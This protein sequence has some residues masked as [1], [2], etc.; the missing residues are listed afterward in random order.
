[1]TP[2]EIARQDIDKLLI[3]AGWDIQDR[4][5]LNLGAK[6]GVAVREFPTQKGPADYMLFV[7]RKAVGVVE[8]KAAGT[9]LSG[10]AEQS[11]KYITSTD[12]NLPK[13]D[14]NLPFAYEST[15]TET[16][17][18]N[19]RDPQPRSRRLFAFHKPETLLEWVQDDSTLRG[20]LQKFPELNVVGLRD[21]QIEAINNLEKSLAKDDPRALLQMA[22]GSGKTFTATSFIYRLLK[23]GKAKRILF[24][25]DRGN[26][27]RQTLKEFQ[28]FTV[29]DDGRK[30]TELYN[31][32][33]LKSPNIDP[34]SKV[35][36]GTIQRM[37]S[38]LSGNQDFDESLEEG[39]QFDNP[40]AFSY[41]DKAPVEYNPK[42]PIE[43]FDFIVTDE[44]HRSIYNLWRQVLEYFDATL[45]GLT[46]TPSKHT[47]GFFNSNLIMEYS[48]ERAVAD[49]INVGYDVYRIKT[50]IGEQGNTINQ[51]TFVDVRDRQTRKLRWEQLDEDLT[52]EASQLDRSVV[53]PD[54]IRTVVRVFKNWLP[55]I[56]PDRDTVP[57]TLIFAKDDNHAE[58]I[59]HIVREVFG[60]GNEFAK[61]ITYRT[62]EN[63]EDLI[64][65]FRNSYFPRIAVTV[66]MIS[67]GTDIKPLECLIFMRDVKSRVYF[68][69][70]KGRGTR[71]IGEDDLKAVTPD[72]EYKNRFVIFDAV[73]VTESVKTDSRTLER[74][75]FV[76]FKSLLES[77]AL[78]TIGDDGIASLAGRIS[79]FEQSLSDTDKDEL[80]QANNGVTLKQVAH[81]LL[82]V[83]DPDKAGTDEQKQQ[84]KQEALNYFDNPDFRQLMLDIKQRNEIVIDLSPDNPIDVPKPEPVAPQELVQ[85]FEEYIKQNQDE[86]TALQIIF[87]KPYKKQVLTFQEIKELRDRLLHAN[88]R[89]T[90][91]QLWHAYRELYKSKVRNARPDRVLTNIVSLVRFAVDKSQD[92]EP[93]PTTVEERFQ[94]WLDDN[95]AKGMQFSDDQLTWLKMIKD[96]VA[97]NGSIQFDGEITSFELPPF[98]DKG[99]IFKA[100]E[101]FGGQ[102]EQITNELNSY[103]VI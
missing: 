67:T 16:F 72:A 92:L 97:V 59:V 78:R 53:A 25:V 73:G 52:Y 61:K 37:Y 32:Q 35:C 26:L 79:K 3:Q 38:I 8:A 50:Q 75:P 68:E 27:G 89:F 99:G 86:I 43:T 30:F 83:I 103:L 31:V 45:I 15:G 51:G 102:L 44:C 21:C 40:P 80:Q 60:K 84:Q 101:V 93:F 94:K 98:S 49:G 64:Q 7:D 81:E 28:K 66:D 100:H 4:S 77:A 47:V 9:T 74:Q 90:N 48:H 54:Q 65:S 14:E 95:H 82:D 33:H 19:E 13:V 41:E 5:R 71:T 6:L 29:P 56:F 87:N 22:T 24:L 76:S 63:V 91:D 18:R 17:F 88:V 2:E 42:L 12:P 20:R 46:A 58:E 36:I 39:S 55:D 23:Y 85:S 11:G 10:V 34:V 70:M 1:M 57:K 96:F 62:G 69:Q